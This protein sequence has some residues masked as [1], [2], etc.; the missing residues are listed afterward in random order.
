MK[1]IFLFLFAG[2]MISCGPSV[3]EFENLKSENTALK[4]QV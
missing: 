1:K 3:T 2:M 4:A